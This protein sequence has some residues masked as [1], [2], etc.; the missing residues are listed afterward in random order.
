MGANM[1]PS[2]ATILMIF[3]PVKWVAEATVT[4]S[5]QLTEYASVRLEV[6]H[7]QAADDA[8]FGGDVTTDPTTRSFV[9]NRDTQDTVTLG[10]SAW[11]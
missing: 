4:L 7:D 10:V 6:R 9:P 5:Y 1:R 2:L 11:F 3:W 8:Y